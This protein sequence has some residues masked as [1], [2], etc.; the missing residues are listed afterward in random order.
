[1]SVTFRDVPLERFGIDLGIQL[2]LLS[3]GRIIF[4]RTFTFVPTYDYSK[5]GITAVFDNEG[6][7]MAKPDAIFEEFDWGVAYPYKEMPTMLA[8]LVQQQ[9]QLT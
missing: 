5:D 2:V 7:S 9:M 4:E 3:D 6:F 1:M 8:W